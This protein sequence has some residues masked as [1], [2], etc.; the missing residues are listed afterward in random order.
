VS[1]MTVQGEAFL[2]AAISLLPDIPPKQE[3][4]ITKKVYS[5]ETEL[6]GF[7]RNFSSFLLYCPGHPTSGPFYLVKG[8]LNAINTYE[9]WKAPGSVGKTKVYLGLLSL[10]ATYYQ[11]K[12]PSHIERVESND[13]LYGCDEAYKTQ[14]HELITGVIEAIMTQ[15]AEIGNKGDL[16]S[17]K[18]QGTLALEFVNILIVTM[19]MN[20]T[21]ATMV[22]RLVQLAQNTKAV[23]AKYLAS[24]LN[25][26]RTQRGSWYEDISNKIAA[27]QQEA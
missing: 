21:S 23:D 5:N 25:H 22:V 8:L 26:I 14:L 11:A 15:L 7:I 16:I 24:T 1:Q 17:K 27:L 12:F 10:F 6:V 3:N 2:K 13:S 18:E 9:P 20:P 4:Q 19:E